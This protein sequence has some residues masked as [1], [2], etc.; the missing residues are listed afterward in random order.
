MPPLSLRKPPSPA[1]CP[2][3]LLNP[4]AKPGLWIRNTFCPAPVQVCSLEW[5]MVSI[6]LSLGW[7]G[8]AGP[9]RKR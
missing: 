6:I 1:S 7:M 8:T 5:V 3:W 9:E 2:T 4:V